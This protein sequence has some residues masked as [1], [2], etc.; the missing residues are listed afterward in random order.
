MLCYDMSTGQLCVSKLTNIMNYQK[1]RR[2]EQRVIVVIVII[3]S[4]PFNIAKINGNYKRL[5]NE[6]SDSIRSHR[7]ESICVVA[8]S[9]AWAHSSST[10]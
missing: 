2:F 9:A 3:A 7:C 10:W 5:S 8:A 4:V 1:Y 6:F